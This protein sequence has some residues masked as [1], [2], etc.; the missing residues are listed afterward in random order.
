M[1]VYFYELMRMLT[2][3]CF[4]LLFQLLS[5]RRF[6]DARV[7]RMREVESTLT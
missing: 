6:I 5:Q 3:K 4:E 1:T 2:A 7:L